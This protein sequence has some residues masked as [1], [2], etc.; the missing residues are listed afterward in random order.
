MRNNIYLLAALGAALFATGCT[1]GGDSDT[2]TPSVTSITIESQSG[3]ARAL[4]GTWISC[5]NQGGVDIREELVVSGTSFEMHKY[6]GTAAATAATATTLPA[7][8]GGTLDSAGEVVA[9]IGTT[10]TVAFLDWLDPATGT[11][12]FAPAPAGL[13]PT[14]LTVVPV[15]GT[16]GG[17]PLVFAAS[18]WINDTNTVYA[19]YQGKNGGVCPQTAAGED[20]CLSTANQYYK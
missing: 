13:T 10:S 15:T 16:W 14:S 12:S 11:S 18:Y 4:D 5:S 8:A 7:C 6:T 2:V 1:G 3:T 17:A 9:T 20:Q 19:M